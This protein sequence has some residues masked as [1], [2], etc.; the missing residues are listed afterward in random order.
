M[1]RVV[2]TGT[3][4]L[5]PLGLDVESTWRSYLDGV[6]GIAPVT[7]F[8]A[9]RFPTT[10]GGE[11]RLH[12]PVRE[13]AGRKWRKFLHRGSALGLLAAEAALSDAG[14]DQSRPDPDRFGIVFGVGTYQFGFD[15]LLHDYRE[16]KRDG[17]G[18]ARVSVI[19]SLRMKQMNLPTALMAHLFDARG[20]SS[21]VATACSSGAQAIGEAFSLVRR[22]EAD[23]VL[24]GGFDSIISP[25]GF[26]AFSLLGA[27]SRRN[28]APA[29][30]SRPFDVERDGFVPSEGAGV[31]VLEALDHARARG[32]AIHG[33][34]V[35][36]GVSMNAFRVSDS[37]LDGSGP[38]I[39]MRRALEDAAM[40]PEE[41]DCINAHGTSTQLNDISETNAV[42]RVFGDHARSVP[43]SSTKSLMGHQIAASGAVEVILCLLAIRDGV[44]PHTANLERP[45]PECDL[46]YVPG[47]PR[48][49]KVKTALT[50]S[51]GFGGSNA[52]LVVREW[53]GE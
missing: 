21:S 7:L 48:R 2:V 37:P 39:S 9:S 28:D 51:F 53:R 15:D 31:L 12:D 36:Y 34:V 27:F 47:G 52:S 19:R 43:V 46:D 50:N 6:S 5:T 45:D 33:E 30:A 41:V 16:F 32:A 17:D 22:G 35:G 38:D 8:D 24:T 13:V 25:V 4:A 29:A 26:A 18:P 1:R 23:V 3:G 14:F 10:F 44:I 40:A 42:K 11:V 49:A 20:P